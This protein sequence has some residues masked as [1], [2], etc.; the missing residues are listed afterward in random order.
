MTKAEKIGRNNRSKA[1]TRAQLMTAGRKLLVTKGLTGV[2]VQQITEEADVGLGSFYNY[3]DS[4]MD[5][6]KAV[7]DEYLEG[8]DLAVTQLVSELSDPAEI[9][10]VSCRYI[11]SQALEKQSF[12]IIKQMPN[13]YIIDRISRRAVRDMKI[14]IKTGRFEVEHP[15]IN[16]KYSTGGILGIMELYSRNEVNAEEINYAV[17]MYLQSLGVD[18]KEAV[19]LVKKPMPS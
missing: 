3:F 10:C 6:L 7:A 4:K 19:S 17:I 15:E 1:R 16:A 8:Y 12:A 13:D 5:V 18:K 2:S 14:G 11:L 9:V